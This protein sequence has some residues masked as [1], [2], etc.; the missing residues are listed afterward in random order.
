MDYTWVRGV[1]FR[2]ICVRASQKR[3]YALRRGIRFGVRDCA[4]KNKI[5][6]D[7]QTIN[8]IISLYDGETSRN[9]FFNLTQYMSIIPDQNKVDAFKLYAECIIK[10]A[11]AF[12]NAAIPVATPTPTSTTVQLTA[13]IVTQ[14]DVCIGEYE[15][16][17]LPHQVYIYCG[18]SIDD[19]ARPRCSSFSVVR[20]NTYG[21][22]KCGYGLDRVFCTGPK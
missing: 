11:P 16:A 18:V 8:S 20:L 3:C 9:V 15:R 7:Q 22:N 1:I 17:C 12:A 19:W 13:P 10:V 4:E 2:R 5:G 6:L 14:Y 21:G